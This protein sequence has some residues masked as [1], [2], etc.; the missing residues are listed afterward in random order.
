MPQVRSIAGGG[1]SLRVDAE[2]NRAKII[3]AAREIFA[4]Q[5]IHAPIYDVAERAGVGVGTLYRRFPTRSDLI[6]G[7][8]ADQMAA[9]ADGV[10]AALA[11]PD[12]WRGFCD[13]IQRLCAVQRSNRG[14]CDVLTMTFPTL[15][16]FET[17]RRQIY[18]GFTELIDAAKAA[19]AL[20]Q[21]FVPEDLLMVLMANAGVV[22]ATGGTAPR[23]SPR[24]LGYL[25]QAFAAPGHEPL[26]PPPSGR[27]MYR[28]LVRLEEAGGKAQAGGRT[29]R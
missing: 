18:A 7:A 2:R 22:A 10:Q 14:F 21:E 15:R 11:D 12:P 6:A 26:P 8:F 3:A 5:G 23:T 4:E 20:R 25:L 1:S 16:K 17:A 27:Q 13:Y 29:P 19:G 28:A 24:L 9:F